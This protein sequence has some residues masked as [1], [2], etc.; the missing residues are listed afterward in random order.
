MSGTLV[1]VIDC[2]STNI[3]AIAIDPYGKIIAQ[4]NRPNQS[5]PQ[6][7]GKP[8]WLIWNLE[9]IWQKISEASREV[10]Y[11]TGPEN[12]GA[13]I[14]TTWGSDGAPVK[15]DGTPT[16][17]PISWQ[18]PRT[19]KIA[20][21]I[22]KE[23]SAWR[24][25]QITGYQVISFNTLLKMIWLR[26]NA[27]EALNEA[28]TWLMM[29]G[30]IVHRL[31][32]QFHIDPTSASTMMAMNLKMRDWADSLLELANLD[33]SFFPEWYEPC[34]IV[35][36]VTEE[37]EKK[38]GIPSETP[39]VVGGHDTQFAMLGSGAKPDDAI[40]SSGTWEILSVRIGSFKP[41]QIGFEEGLIIEADVQPNLWNPQLLMIGSAVLEWVRE[42]F[43]PELKGQDYDAMIKEAEKTPP[44]AGDVTFIPSLFRES[45]P[46]RKY[47]ALGTILGL[48]LQTSRDHI[49]RAALEGLSFQLREALRILTEAAGF[50]VSGIRAVG[51]GSKNALW[52]RIRADV[53]GLPIVV[54]AQKEA[55]AL[56]A[57]I[58]A[59]VGIGR[60]GSIA[61]AERH[62]FSEGE[63]L[64]PGVDRVFYKEVSKRYGKA[65]L[66][67]KDFYNEE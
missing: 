10:T 44:G 4:A 17:P 65:L 14:V 31:T 54:P 18:C 2:G 57:A 66:N 59:F 55:T 41:N 64:E 32:G 63:R 6:T 39:V 20:K 49:Y 25:F 36:H 53:T 51:G 40:L 47:G 7:N 9:E 61:E 12:I 35:G 28:Y 5:Y 33:S 29:P 52:N 45:G 37:A 62:L 19:R 24:I 42:L 1:L 38:C 22:V 30:L 15:R 56:G 46:A 58:T 16:Y 11:T 60:Y 50:H 13:V 43:F 26:R 21:N 23:I 3:R 48:T 67:L 27:P 8:G 34:Q